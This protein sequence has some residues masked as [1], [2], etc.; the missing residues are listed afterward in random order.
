MD[1]EIIEITGFLLAV[2]FAL[3]WIRIAVD[4]LIKWTDKKRG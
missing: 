1:E 4:W 2:G 3:L